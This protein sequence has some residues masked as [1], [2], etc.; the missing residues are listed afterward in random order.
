MM[1]GGTNACTL[2]AMPPNWSLRSKAAVL[3]AVLLPVPTL[4]TLAKEA[5]APGIG[6]PWQYQQRLRHHTPPAFFRFLAYN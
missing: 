4:P 1:L 3:L 6:R 5:V 2:C